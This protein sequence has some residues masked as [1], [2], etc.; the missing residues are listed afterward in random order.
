MFH[1]VIG[2]QNI[3]LPF[4]TE[5]GA[6]GQ[7]KIVAGMLAKQQPGDYATIFHDNGAVFVKLSAVDA[8]TWTKEQRIT[9]PAGMMPGPQGMRM[10]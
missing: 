8:V 9:Q 5:A 3:S 4:E 6:E 10:S 7:Y 2:T 1:M